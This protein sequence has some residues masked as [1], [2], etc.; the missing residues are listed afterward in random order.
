[1]RAIVLSIVLVMLFSCRSKESATGENGTEN[2][3]IRNKYAGLMGV[4]PD[5]IKNV[6]LYKFI[7]DWY[8]APYKYG[9]KSKT[10]VDCSGFVSQLYAIVYGQTLSGSSASIH[11]ASDK[12][13]K[14]NL[15]EGDLVFFKISSDQV[16]HIGVYLQNN[17]FVHAS[18]KRG[19]VINSLQEEYYTK[20]Y[21]SGGRIP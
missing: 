1:M 8:G 21:F 17:R 11:K 5:N 12:V 9:G 20:Y 10:G 15:Q 2:A 16:S 6:K 3:R 4:S 19:V 14:K 18:T 7:D 13:S